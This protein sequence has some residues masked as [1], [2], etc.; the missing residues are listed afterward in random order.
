MDW[1]V[2]SLEAQTYETY[3]AKLA[4]IQERKRSEGIQQQFVKMQAMLKEREEYARDQA[5]DKAEIVLM[6]RQALEENLK[7]LTEEVEELS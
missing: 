6:Q 1:A 3:R 4:L 2:K 7:G 5:S